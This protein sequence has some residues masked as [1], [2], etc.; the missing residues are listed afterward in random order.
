LDQFVALTYNAAPQI[1][2]ETHSNDAYAFTGLVNVNRPAYS[3]NGL[4]QYLAAGSAT[5]GYDDNGNLT[6]DGAG[7][8]FAY[9]AENRLI[10]VTT[11]VKGPPSYTD[12]TSLEY[13]PLG[14]LWHVHKD[15]GLSS[16]GW[17]DTRFLY[18]GDALVAEY[19]GSG[20]LTNRYV[21]GSNAAAD[22]PLVWYAGSDLTGKRWLHAD[23]RGSIIAA[24]SAGS[25]GSPSINSYDE[26]GIPG[27]ANTGRF[28][29]TGQA[30]IGEI[31]LYYYKARFYSPTL[32]RFMQTDPIG[33]A[34]QINLYGYVDDDP[35]DDV[36]PSGLLK[37][38]DDGTNEQ[39]ASCGSRLAGVNNCSGESGMATFAQQQQQQHGSK[40]T[41]VSPS[42]RS[43]SR[44]PMWK[45][46]NFKKAWDRAH[47]IGNEELARTRKIAPEGGHNDLYDAERHARWTYR[48]AQELGWKW[49]DLFSGG[50]E[51]WDEP[52]H[53]QPSNELLM[54][55][56]NNLIGI[57]AARNGQPIPT[58]ASLGLIYI[59]N[60][61]GDYY[62]H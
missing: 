54:D 34:D 46:W 58:V 49:A 32:G 14:R 27:S 51:L 50:H 53:F 41:Q 1:A 23:R 29:Y 30:W 26:Y 4:N 52:T 31:G 19:D 39:P 48:M 9:D 8:S 45:T 15:F 3:V 59:H 2:T 22:D 38:G 61:D 6:S 60:E 5:F 55:S 7:N 47:Q 12:V 57:D 20:A 18:D 40:S 62:A 16:M 13:D 35:I 21:H 28:Q 43:V 33:Y 24:T 44:A 17:T 37:T 10:S 56:H 25:G 11:A 36:D 42:T